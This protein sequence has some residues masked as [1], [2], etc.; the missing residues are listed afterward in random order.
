M[1]PTGYRLET[2]AQR[3]WLERVASD[4]QLEEPECLRERAAVLERLEAHFGDA[5]G[6]GAEAS[7][8]A[9]ALRA[10][11][12]AVDQRLFEQLR[13]D[14]RC[15]RGRERLLRLAATDVAEGGDGYD[16]RDD[17]VAGILALA[18]PGEV[19][20][21]GEDMVFYQPTPAR[22]VFDL[23]AR[24][25]L[26]RDDVLVDLG[27]GLGHVPLL[28]GLCTDAR[29]IGVE[30]QGAYVA[31]A[32]AAAAALNLDRVTF[33]EQD[34]RAA[35]F[36]TGTVFYLYTPFGGSILRAVL[37]ALR[38]QAARRPIRVSSYGPCTRVLA[39][40]PWLAATAPVD[41]ARVALF[42]SAP[43]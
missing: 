3:A 22:H 8:L 34:A 32:R 38:A 17:L 26:G 36:S 39:G 33:V 41:P 14:L 42:T 16:H 27:S 35:D 2:D 4:A 1:R 31:C 7:C 18:T 43:R 24:A 5:T 11:L 30:L 21:P 15:G 28:A 19:P 37:D 40:E 29:A 10:R 20:E 12:E 6:V 9:A 25:E 23:I 13:A